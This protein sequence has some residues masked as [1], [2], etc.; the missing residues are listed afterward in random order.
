[1]SA[2]IGNAVM[3][4]DFDGTNWTVPT[5]LPGSFGLNNAVGA[6]C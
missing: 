2:E 5:S 4:A 3:V 6:F 1:M